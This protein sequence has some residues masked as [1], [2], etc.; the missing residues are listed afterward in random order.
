MMTVF[1]TGGIVSMRV[2][3]DEKEL[4]MVAV[5]TQTPIAIIF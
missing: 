2:P 5:K 3:G 1:L 4:Q